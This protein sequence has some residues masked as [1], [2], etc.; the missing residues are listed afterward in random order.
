MDKPLMLFD[1]V[2]RRKKAM[3]ISDSGVSVAQVRRYFAAPGEK[4]R[5]ASAA[6]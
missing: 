4:D 3:I 6:G 2:M 1:G 5:L